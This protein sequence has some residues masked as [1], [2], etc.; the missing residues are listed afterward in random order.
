[1]VLTHRFPYPPDKGERIRTYHW[2]KA[3]ALR[4][5]VDLLSLNDVP[6][7]PEYQQR[8]AEFVDRCRVVL[9]RPSRRRSLVRALLTHRSITEAHFGSA[10]FRRA[11]A[12]WL[13][14]ARYDACLAVCSSMGQY[15]LDPLPGAPALLVDFV[16][17]DSAK[18]QRYADAHRG[19]SR[20]LYRR[21]AREV[22]RLERDLA[23]QADAAFAISTEECA[24]LPALRGGR[25]P[26][27]IPNGV[28]TEY[29]RPSQDAG[30]SRSLVFTGQMDY[31]PN[32][33][34]VTWFGR[35]VWPALHRQF[36]ALTWHIVGRDPARAVRAL[37][38]LPN[39][40]VTGPVSDVRPF[41]ASSIALAPLRIACGVQNKVLEALA[42]GRPVIASPASAKPL[43]VQPQRDLLLA[44][45]PADWIAA[46]S[47]LLCDDQLARELGRRGREAILAHYR[48]ESI[49]RRMRDAVAA[50]A[51]PPAG[52]PADQPEPSIAS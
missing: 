43:A 4:D 52:R 14:A 17:A 5:T 2:L 39:V 29:F 3:L 21:E 31:F 8:V 44:D 19:L 36:P 25:P 51:V 11:L 22:G 50:V 40:T 13:A 28:D 9:I 32:V 49:T 7:P 24:R 6:V 23:A 26:T 38:G 18:W 47:L 48:W 37:A 10:E 34:A 20:R 45:Q 41:L 42:S 30:R 27:A 46:V 33:D 12:E 35:E 16:D 1:L 15:L